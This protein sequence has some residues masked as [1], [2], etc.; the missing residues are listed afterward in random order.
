MQEKSLTALLSDAIDL[1]ILNPG[2]AT[3]AATA[4]GFV[5]L[6]LGE[7]EY[8][9]VQIR[10]ALPLASPEEYLSVAD[11]EGNEICII[12]NLSDL[13]ESQREVVMGELNRRY[14]SPNVLEV[15]SVKDQLG[16]VYFGLRIK[17]AGDAIERTCAIKDVNRNIR[18]TSDDSVILFDVDGN[19]YIIPSLKALS[20]KSRK[21][22]EPYL[23]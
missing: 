23:F 3:F 17:G 9:R 6:K 13:S 15:L 19:R 2:E 14:Y 21:R 11:G 22:L 4:G 10:R 7:K 20:A 16:Y 5:K 1:G 8:P 12:R 18:M